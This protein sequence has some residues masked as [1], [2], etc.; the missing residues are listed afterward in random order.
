MAL[1]NRPTEESDR[2]RMQI[3]NVVAASLC[4]CVIFL[5]LFSRIFLFL[6]LFLLH[7][8]L[9][10]VSSIS[11]LC[12]LL[13][14]GL[15]PISSVTSVFPHFPHQSV[16]TC[17]SSLFSN[18]SFLTPFIH[19]NCSFPTASPINAKRLT[20]SFRTISFLL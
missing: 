10:A 20:F 9:I 14:F 19:V 15:L 11:D 5:L 13:I 1:I 17:R 18:P 16:S 6:S 4:L 7:L 8:L 3:P 2:A 12:L